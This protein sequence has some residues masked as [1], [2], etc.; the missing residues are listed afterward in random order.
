VSNN[1]IIFK[2][3]DST[4]FTGSHLICHWIT[5]GLFL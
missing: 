2:H 5:A 1:G 3:S 4:W